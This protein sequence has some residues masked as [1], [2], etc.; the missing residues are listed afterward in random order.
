MQ[1]AGGNS[2]SFRADIEGLR[3]IAIMMVLFYHLGIKHVSGGFAGVDVFFVISGFLITGLLLKEVERT[4]TIS[5]VL[6]YSRRAKRLFPA[7]ALVLLATTLAVYWVLPKTRWQEASGDIFAA[8]AYFVNWRL[9]F[10]SVDYLAEDSQPSLV[11]HFWSL[12]VEEQY[13]LIWPALLVLAI[14]L[15]R[16]RVRQRPLIWGVLLLVATPSFAWSIYQTSQEQ[17]V[18]YFSTATR[19]W[20]LATGGAVAMLGSSLRRLPDFFLVAMGWCGVLALVLTAVFITN[21]ISWPGYAA[22]LPTLGTAAIIVSGYS[23]SRYGVSLLLGNRLFIHIGALSYSLY[24]W[25]WPVIEIAKVSYGELAAW[26]CILLVAISY[27]LAW[28]TYRFVENPIRHSRAMQ[29]NPRYALSAG[30]NFTLLGVVSAGALMIAFL[31]Q[32][33]DV[34]D[35]PQ[36]MGAMILKGKARDNP[37]GKPVDRVDWITPDPAMARSDVPQYYEDCFLPRSSSEPKECYY[38]DPSGD[39]TIALV[40]DSKIGQWLPA[41]IKVAEKNSWRI[42]LFNKGACGF[43]SAMLHVYGEAY[44]E[45][46][47]WNRLV[48]SRLLNSV[49]PDYVLT[50]QVRSTSGMPGTVKND[51][52]P[53]LVDWWTQLEDSGIDVVA[54]GD[55]PHPKKNVYECVESN[56]EE[57]TKC[58][59]PR[60][61]GAGTAALK[62]AARTMGNVDF[63]DLSDAICPTEHCAPVIGNV[64][65]YRQ[66]S[67][68]TKTYSETLAPRLERAL[69]KIG[70]GSAST[71]GDD[72][73]SAAEQG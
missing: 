60:R 4:G 58:A 48:L 53:A 11:Q 46:Y 5:L 21:E 37:A 25:H 27:S 13:Y 14:W 57:L 40:G 32:T 69:K 59:F 35:A 2:S 15:L 47:E 67:H 52:V 70:V 28:L 19:M 41:M 23:K 1:K 43:N 64:L 22:M 38:G 16:G 72:L 49:K 45:C 9:A 10:R 42:V 65:I 63:I 6:F 68:I 8:A 61:P 73:N 7:A 31:Q 55:N 50:S 71:D 62:K 26:H 56:R 18:A 34:R 20:Q 66:G 44:K 33:R 54:L 12:S 17:G 30:L 3:A 36:A 29:D 24:L 51:L 39:I